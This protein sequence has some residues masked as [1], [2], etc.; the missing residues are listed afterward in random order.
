[1]TKLNQFINRFQFTLPITRQP[2]SQAGKSAAVLL[3]IIN[4][5]IPTLLLTQRS[6][7]LRSHAG[8]VAFPGGMS[9]PEDTTLAATALREAYEEVAIPPEKVQIL[10]QLTPM[11]SYGGYQ[12]TPIVGL[13][14]DNI[15][16]QAN[17]SEVSSIFEV[18][19]FDALSLHRYKYV[20]INRSGHK[21]R[22]FFYWYNDRLV[23]GLTA[24]IIHQLALQLDSY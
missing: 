5:P 11:L 15:H 18:P 10:G 22:I 20:D 19:L 14:P 17:P 4:K 6:P 23:W 2:I 16:Y 3:P 1:M 7:F 9:D 21:N 13:L 12:V 8:Q 24:S